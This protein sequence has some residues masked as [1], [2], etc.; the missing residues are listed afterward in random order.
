[1]RKRLSHQITLLLFFLTVAIISIGSICDSKM[2]WLK[3]EEISSKI[4]QTV[5][6][7]LAQ[8]PVATKIISHALGQVKIPIHPQRIVVLDAKGEFILDALLALGI[9]PVGLTR[10]STCINS[11]PFSEFLGSLPTVGN[12][13]QPSLE[14]ILSLKP[15]LIIG[16]DWQRNFYPLLSKI[17][18]T[19]MINI[20]SNGNDFKRH[21][22][23]LA[24][25]LDRGDRAEGILTEYNERI[26]KFRQQFGER[27]E[28]KTV[29]LLGFWGSTIHVYKPELL[30]HAQVMRDAGIQFIP[31]YENL[32]DDY[33]RLNIET[34]SDWDADFL[35]IDF[36]YKEE[37]EN[38][39]SLSFLKEPIWLTLKA[40]RNKQVYITT[41]A[42]GG[43]IM[44]NQLVDELYGYFINKL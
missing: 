41:W 3:Q 23:Y 39:K 34:V 27:L 4:V 29:S 24:E 10:C 44:A 42:G 1:M 36:Y 37:F 17:A 30:F 20:Y 7:S 9:K 33:L 12:E 26:R 16:Y 14:K 11:D 15:D 18:P 43:P 19:I 32:K 5:P 21:F 31:T 28:A 40:V 8:K 2:L 22:K 6:L 13:E 35:F 38:L 25:I